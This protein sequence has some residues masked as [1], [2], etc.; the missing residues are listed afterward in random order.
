M[1]SP[2]FLGLHYTL[3][4]TPSIYIICNQH[5][6]IK[7]RWKARTSSFRFTSVY[8][9]WKIEAC[10]WQLLNIIL[11]VTK[12]I[13]DVAATSAVFFKKKILFFPPKT[14]TLLLQ[15]RNWELGH[16]KHIC[17]WRVLFVTITSFYILITLDMCD[18]SQV[19]HR[20]TLPHTS[21]AM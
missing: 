6:I 14:L 3:F 11:I 2:A 20:N 13:F 1:L 18:N 10:I 7:R 12:L 8:S 19:E 17:N 9:Q 16:I 4:Y 15:R 5:K 21:F